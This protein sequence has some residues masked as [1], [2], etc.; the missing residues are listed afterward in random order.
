MHKAIVEEDIKKD[1]FSR[2]RYL[3][4]SNIDDDNEDDTVRNDCT[5]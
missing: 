3:K 5:Y 2:Y 4:L 1:N